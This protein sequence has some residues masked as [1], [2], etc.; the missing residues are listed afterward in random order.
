MLQSYVQVRVEGSLVCLVI[1]LL[2][3]LRL[4]WQALF[5]LQRRCLVLVVS[6]ALRGRWKLVREQGM[7]EGFRIKG[8]LLLSHGQQMTFKLVSNAPVSV[9]APVS[10]VINSSTLYSFFDPGVSGGSFDRD[11]YQGVS[12]VSRL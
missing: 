8:I 5:E 9:P 4:R 10:A 2:R 11:A 7:L 1:S 12:A 3:R 6:E